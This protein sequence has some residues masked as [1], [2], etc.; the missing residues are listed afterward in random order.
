[1]AQSTEVSGDRNQVNVVGRD[2]V[3]AE[4]YVHEQ[5]EF[6]RP[7][8]KRFQSN[9]ILRPHIQPSLVQKALSQHMLVLGG[10]S[11]L[12][13]LS[14]VRHI[15]WDLISS[16]PEMKS[17]GAAQPLSVLE[18]VKSSN[19]QRLVGRLEETRER[20]VF[21]LPDIEPQHV[22]YDLTAIH[23]AAYSQKHHVII[24]TEIPI[25]MW[26]LS[27]KDSHFWQR[28][29]DNDIYESEDLFGHFLDELF[30]VQENLPTRIAKRLNTG[31]QL[32]DNFEGKI[33]VIE[34]IQSLKT[35]D[36]ITFFVQLLSAQK[37]ELSENAIEEYVKYSQDN[38]NVIKRWFHQ[39]L[40]RREQMLAIGLCFFDGLFEDQFF[41][42]LEEIIQQDWQHREP[43]LL[44]LDY[45]DL[46]KLQHFCS[47][48]DLDHTGRLIDL[49]QAD[50]RIEIR[51]PEQRQIILNAAWD[52]HRRQ[53]IAALP[54]LV[55]LVRQ[56][57]AN[58]SYHPELYGSRQMRR[59]LRLVISDLLSHLGR[60]APSAVERPLLELAADEEPGVQAV[61][62]RA[63]ARL[64]EHGHHERLSAG[65]IR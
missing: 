19:P 22:S 49:E 8:L 57:V 32:Y 60:I 21:I 53:I 6:Y 46:D 25:S 20:T 44:A 45:H 1:M 55:S 12:D 38:Q 33:R 43:T 17:D 18:W 58:R 26:H 4:T 35:P 51:T 11:A 29:P 64:Y 27:D 3:F 47:L 36:N 52:T 23:E 39:F 9:N 10:P 61:A 65:S 5:S 63:M 16:L 2:L 15:A 54:I 31:L 30:S 14:L 28:V 48:V 56:S 13:K 24:S 42:A 50:R 59:Q 34:I 7:N 41:A 37:K 40:N 62:G